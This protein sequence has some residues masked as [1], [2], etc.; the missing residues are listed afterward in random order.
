MCMQCG[1]VTVSA[2]LVS[3]CLCSAHPRSLMDARQAASTGK[4]QLV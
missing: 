3:F 4:L 2:K 1:V